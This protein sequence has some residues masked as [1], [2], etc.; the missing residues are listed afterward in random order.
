MPSQSQ[1]LVD[2]GKK[3]ISP[4]RTYGDR[5]QAALDSC[6]PKS[7]IYQSLLTDEGLKK[8]YN[9]ILNGSPTGE[10]DSGTGLTYGK[11]PGLG[12]DDFSTEFANNGVPDIAALEKTKDGKAF[13]SGEGAPTTP[14]V[15]PL[16]SA[17]DMTAASQPPHKKENVLGYDSEGKL[18]PQTEFGSGFGSLANPSNTSNDI[19]N[20][21]LGSL[22][23]GR[24]Y[25]NSDILG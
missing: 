22:I 1:W 10:L 11:G 14:Y 17:P 9:Q 8:T 25:K 21:K 20:Q 13:G 7:P 19:D 4:Q 16:T 12:I 6:F 5:N 2:D 15:P 3:T 18:I 23:S 24:S